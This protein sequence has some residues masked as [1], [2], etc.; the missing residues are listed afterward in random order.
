MHIFQHQKIRHLHQIPL[1][2][3]TSEQ[4]DRVSSVQTHKEFSGQAFDKNA[5][6]T[7]PFIWVRWSNYL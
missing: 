2:Y 1:Y 6:K 3:D 5:V 4:G 7:D